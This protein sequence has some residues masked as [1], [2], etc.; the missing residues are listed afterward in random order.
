VKPPPDGKSGAEGTPKLPKAKAPDDADRVEIS[1]TSKSLRR[2]SAHP[3]EALAKKQATVQERIASGF[4]NRE[5]VVN[6]IARRI[7]DLLGF[8]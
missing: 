8:K 4:Y 7:L 5:E 6:H 3:D 1:D 2:D